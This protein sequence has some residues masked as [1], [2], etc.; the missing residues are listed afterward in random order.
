[1]AFNVNKQQFNR[2]CFASHTITTYIVYRRRRRRRCCR[3]LSTD[4]CWSRVLQ[5]FIIIIVAAHSG[6]MFGAFLVYSSAFFMGSY[7]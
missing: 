5:N 3:S 2:F 6:K 4:E 7:R 1:M